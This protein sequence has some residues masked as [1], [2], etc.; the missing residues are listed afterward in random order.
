MEGFT[1]I[2]I[3]NL[4]SGNKWSVKWGPL[5]V[6]DLMDYDRIQKIFEI[7][8]PLAVMHFAAHAYVGES[9]KYPIKYYNNNIIG[10]LNL[11]NAMEK[12]NVKYIIYSSTCS[13]YGIP[14]EIPITESHLQKP[15]NPYGT[16]KLVVEQLLNKFN[17]ESIIKSII[18]RYF[19]AAGADLDSELGEWHDPEPHLIPNIIDVLLGNKKTINIYGNDYDTHDGTCIRDYIH[20]KDLAIAHIL[21]LKYLLRINK[22]EIF[23]LGTGAGYSVYEIIKEANNITKSIVNYKILERRQGD[24]DILVANAD[25]AKQKLKWS[26]KNSSIERILNTSINWY[27]YG[28][29]SYET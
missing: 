10:S 5:E 22:S 24:P 7:Y 21:S 26:P 15:I 11:L 19:N 3:D 28:R 20:V 17:G 14:K 12:T 8:K 9:I 16:S 4:I 13:T 29:K 23:N 6:V 25:K 1:P 2:V 27:K 18:L